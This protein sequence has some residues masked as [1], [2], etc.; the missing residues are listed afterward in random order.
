M[1]QQKDQRPTCPHCNAPLVQAGEPD[2]IVDQFESTLVVLYR[3]RRCPREFE[4]VSTW[5]E[6]TE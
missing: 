3:C 6:L 4:Y 2:H 1:N 5:R